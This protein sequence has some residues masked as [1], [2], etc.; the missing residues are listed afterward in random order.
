[1]KAVADMTEA[2]KDQ[3]RAWIRNWEKLGPILEDL[4]R[5][6]IRQADTLRAIPAFDGAFESAVRDSPPKP[7]SGLIEQQRLFQKAR[8]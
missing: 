4:R 6:D 2:E 1:M 8:K 3:V 5:Q 7:W